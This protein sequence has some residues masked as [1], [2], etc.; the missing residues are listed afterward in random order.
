MK[1]KVSTMSLALLMSNVLL[2]NHLQ[3]ADIPKYFSY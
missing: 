3:L 1:H 2:Y